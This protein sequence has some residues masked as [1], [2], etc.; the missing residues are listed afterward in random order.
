M[1][2]EKKTAPRRS[3]LI[4][5]ALQLDLATA[6][7]AEAQTDIVSL[8]VFDVAGERFALGVEHTEGVVD[9]PRVSPLPR[10]PDGIV[11][12]ASV[13]GRMTIVVDLSLNG[14]RR[15]DRRRL[16][17]IKGDAQ[18]G[19]LADHIEGVLQLAAKKLR[20]TA[21]RRQSS[22]KQGGRAEKESAWPTSHFFKSGDR[23]V[24]VIDVERLAEF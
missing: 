9:C 20:A 8:L 10:P 3:S 23:Q 16:V 24:P 7:P 17:L 22:L 14:G 6:S 4:P 18:L 15:G 11:G 13:R 19:L 2:K 12:V 21:P 5:A 1:K